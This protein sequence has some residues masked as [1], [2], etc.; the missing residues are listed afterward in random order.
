VEP[1]VTRKYRVGDI[2]HC[3]ADI[4]KARRLLGYQPR[5]DIQAGL[6]DLAEWLSHAPAQDNFM[7][8]TQELDRRGLRL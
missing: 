5:M 1:V 6:V 7:R 8:A 4:D 2:R 3:F